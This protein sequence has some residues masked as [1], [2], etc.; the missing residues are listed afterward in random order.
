MTFEFKCTE[1]DVILPAA[2]QIIGR[3]VRCP[4]CGELVMVAREPDPDADAESWGWDDQHGET[5]FDVSGDELQK[6]LQEQE[7]EVD[8]LIAIREEDTDDFSPSGEPREK[9]A[10]LAIGD[11]DDFEPLPSQTASSQPAASPQIPL[12]PQAENDTTLRIPVPTVVAEGPTEVRGKSDPPA[13]PPPSAADG[14]PP[15]TTSRGK[16]SFGGPK[17]EFEE[18]EMDMTPMVDVTFLL[19]IFFM[20]TASF[21]LEKAISSQA[22]Q[23]DDPST[24]VVEPE[25][26]DNADVVFVHIDEYN[27]YHVVYGDKEP[28]QAPSP[29]ELRR[30]LK[31]ASQGIMID[32]KRVVPKE[33]V[34]ATHPKATHG[35]VVAA[36]DAGTDVGMEKIQPILS[37]E[38]F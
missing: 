31:I 30:Q 33:M 24:N 29:H 36:I 21:T 22:E 37:E 23:Q 38:E 1:C 27:T 25:F 3:R 35:R 15:D 9:P 7:L 11:A 13:S 12:T 26:E 8:N 19:L 10:E 28:I 14:Q 34:I 2:D 6:R 17:R 20:V 16:A 5:R 32:G 18:G 4:E